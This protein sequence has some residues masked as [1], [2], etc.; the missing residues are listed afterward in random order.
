[1]KNK[2]NEKPQIN[3]LIIILLIIFISISIISSCYTNN[4]KNFNENNSLSILIE[5]RDTIK[6][7]TLDGIEVFLINNTDRT[8]NI[9]EKVPPSGIMELYFIIQTKTNQEYT[10]EPVILNWKADFSKI[11][12]IEPNEKYKLKSNITHWKINNEELSK[13]KFVIKG[14]LV[15]IYKS[16][17]SNLETNIEH[18]QGKI[19]SDSKNV[20][21]LSL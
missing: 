11:I 13:N 5:T 20:V 15:A 3:S 7:P 18:W 17:T 9:W 21:I 2:R 16:D 8:I 1:M 12:Q 4:A 19:S 6:L 14:K 10:I